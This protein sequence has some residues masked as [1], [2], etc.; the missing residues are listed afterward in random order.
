MTHTFTKTETRK[1]ALITGYTGQDGTFLTEYLLDL[2]Y[3]VIA[4]CRRVST[5]PPH[6]VRG[7]FDFSQ[8]TAEGRLILEQGD[9]LSVNSLIRIINKHRPA[10]VYNLA[11]QSHVGTSFNQPEFTIE[12]DLI[13]VVNLITA[14]EAVESSICD[15]ESRYSYR[16]KLY[17]ASTSEMFGDMKPEISLDPMHADDL[18]PVS[19]NESTRLHPNS[20]YAIAKA[21]AHYYCQ[22]K[23]GQGRFI[24]CGILFNHESEIRGGDFVTQKI[25]RGVVSKL[26]DGDFILELGNLDSVRDWGYAGDYVTAMHSMLQHTEADDFVVATGNT[27]TVREFVEAAVRAAG[28][29][30]GVEWHGQGVDETGYLKFDNSTDKQPFVK[31][32]PEYYRPNDVTYLK[33]D[34]RRAAETLGWLSGTSFDDMVEIMVKAEKARQRG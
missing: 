23:R 8:A 21:A 1:V 19:L 17:Q 20:P 3:T 16:W 25:V 14:L 33:G 32:N 6:R 9:L 10:E 34:A 31:V 4:L 12:A 15:R 2:G 29:H 7:R 27:H 5:E 18:Q 13:G 11:A 22:M 28:W 30:A 24:S 26:S